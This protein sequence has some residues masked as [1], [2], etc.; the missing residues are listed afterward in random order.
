MICF[1]NK[2]ERMKKRS[3]EVTAN[4]NGGPEK[5]FKYEVEEII[6]LFT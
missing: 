6:G 2:V 4:M 1:S 3:S 5:I